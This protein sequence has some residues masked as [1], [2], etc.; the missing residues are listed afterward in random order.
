MARAD[1][2]LTGS[3]A[4]SNSFSS[5]SGTRT[6]RLILNRFPLGEESQAPPQKLK[7][8]TAEG[9]KKIILNMDTIKYI[10]SA[11]LS[12]SPRIG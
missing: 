11:E 12:G 2:S 9:N 1:L 10:D 4:V 5:T 6:P 7:A 3:G 8:L